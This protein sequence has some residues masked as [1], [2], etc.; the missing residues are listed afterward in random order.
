MMRDAHELMQDAK[1]ETPA[2]TPRRAIFVM[3]GK[4]KGGGGDALKSP[5]PP[6]THGPFIDRDGNV[7]EDIG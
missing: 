7:Y 5:G 3:E 6:E 2:V 1:A 4:P